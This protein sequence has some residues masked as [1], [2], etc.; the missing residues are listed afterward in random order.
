MFPDHHNE[1]DTGG[2]P[3]RPVFVDP[4]GR[5]RTLVRRI[6]IGVCAAVACYGILLVA[7]L[8]GAPTLPAALV[9][10]PVPA[11]RVT[12]EPPAPTSS[13]PRP[14]ASRPE[15][16]EAPAT[17][18]ETSHTSARPAPAGTTV[19]PGTTPPGSAATSSP[20]GADRRNSR[21]PDLPPGQ[22]RTTPPGSGR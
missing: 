20:P 22:T 10:L 3:A 6:A 15:S 17:E 19:S 21:A 16:S 1:N 14:T 12:S 13:G 5:R 2:D 8:F 18:N 7:A 4:S 11:P 9:P